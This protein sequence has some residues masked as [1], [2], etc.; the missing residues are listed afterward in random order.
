VQGSSGYGMCAA[1]KRVNFLVCNVETYVSTLKIS[2][3]YNMME[4]CLSIQNL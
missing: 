3:V 1:Y 4:I 2:R